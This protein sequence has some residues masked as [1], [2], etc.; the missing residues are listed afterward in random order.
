MH[1]KV[2]EQML[3][4]YKAQIRPSL[5]YCSH[6]W[7][8]VPKHTLGLLDSIQKRAI[9]LIANPELTR[10]LDSLEHRRKVADLCLY[11]RYYYGK[12]SSELANLIPPKAVSARRIRLTEAGHQHRVNLQTPR[13]S[14]Y[15]DSFFWRTTSLWNG[16]PP[17][18][19]P[20][21]Y[22][23]QRFKKNVHRHLRVSTTPGVI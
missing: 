13:T 19:F 3:T 4:L 23:L 17:H 21:Q 1:R 9:R 5:E 20:E 16:L 7:S 15:R 18:I 8:S 2:H 22:N 14:L 11:Y 12:C 10:H 6:I